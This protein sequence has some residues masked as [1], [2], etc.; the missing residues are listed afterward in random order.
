MDPHH[1]WRQS[2]GGPWEPWNLVCLCRG[3]HSWVHDHPLVSQ[4]LGLLVPEWVV[5]Q[6]PDA[7]ARL[8]ALAR[9]GHFTFAPWLVAEDR[10]DTAS[11]DGRFVGALVLEV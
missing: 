2:Q 3:S 6:H 10:I 8:R 4:S 7:P 9:R 11:Q 5:Q 1:V